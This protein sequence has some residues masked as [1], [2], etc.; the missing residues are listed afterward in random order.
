ML[1]EAVVHDRLVAAEAVQ[2]RPML[3]GVEEG[4]QLLAEEEGEVVRLFPQF[5]LRKHTWFFLPS[6]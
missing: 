3:E 5:A 2:R 6:G 1:V 4:L